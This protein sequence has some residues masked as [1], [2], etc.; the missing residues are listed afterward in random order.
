MMEAQ[1]GTDGTPGRKDRRY[2]ALK[3]EQPRAEDHDHIYETK[4]QVYANALDSLNAWIDEIGD[5]VWAINTAYLNSY[6]GQNLD[7]NK[8]ARRDQELASQV[9]E[10]IRLTNDI[11]DAIM[12]IRKDWNSRHN[13]KYSVVQT[14]HL[15]WDE[16][17]LASQVLEQIRLTAPK[18]VFRECRKVFDLAS[19]AFMLVT[20]NKKR[21]G[22]YTLFLKSDKKIEKARKGLD[23]V[24]KV[25][26][27]EFAAA[28]LV[29]E[30]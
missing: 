26:V 25:M 30:W 20:V 23:K 24:L 13:Y 29:F 4:R 27:E 2:P 11:S 5:A 19:Q 12:A 18:D 14:H 8:L 1:G 9:L 10:Q 22:A 17:D 28:D 15:S 3:N 7:P 6:N 21:F 16:K